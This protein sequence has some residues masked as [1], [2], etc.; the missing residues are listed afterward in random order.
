MSN[1]VLFLI[2]L[3]KKSVIQMNSYLLL[4]NFN[5]VIQMFQLM[6][7][8]HSFKLNSKLYLYSKLNKLTLIGQISKQHYNKNLFIILYLKMMI[9]KF[10]TK[11]KL[12]A[13]LQQVKNFIYIINNVYVVLQLT[14]HHN[15]LQ[16][17]YLL[18][19]IQIYILHLQIQIIS[20]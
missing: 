17:K 2:F 13:L 3:L 18:I 1:Q 6:I 5:L 16:I 4:Y 20:I 8:I 14:L 11:V 7:K 19:M 10:N 15:N 12:L 9:M